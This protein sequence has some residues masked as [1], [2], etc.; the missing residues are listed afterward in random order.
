M[1]RTLAKFLL[2]YGKPGINHHGITKNL[3]HILK[4]RTLRHDLSVGI[5]A[6]R[7]WARR[8]WDPYE[9]RE[10]YQDWLPASVTEADDLPFLP[11][12]KEADRTDIPTLFKS[13]GEN[14][15]LSGDT[16]FIARK[17]A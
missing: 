17:K 10:K 5:E 16:R 7:L 8:G 12:K 1:R 11:S 6:A 9:E 15:D 2:Y 4:S 3:I 13:Q 14:S